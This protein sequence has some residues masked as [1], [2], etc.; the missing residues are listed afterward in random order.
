MCNFDTFSA[1]ALFGFLYCE[2]MTAHFPPRTFLTRL[3]LLALPT[4]PSIGSVAWAHPTHA[5]TNGTTESHTH[6]PFSNEVLPIGYDNNDWFIP[7]TTP[8]QSTP[9]PA[10]TSPTQATPSDTQ[11]PTQPNMQPNTQPKSYSDAAGTLTL[12]SGAQDWQNTQRQGVTLVGENLAV[13]DEAARGVVT[14]AVMNLP[15]FNELLPS[16][17]TRTWSKGRANLE[18]R[19]LQNGQWSAWYSFGTWSKAEGRRSA[20][21]QSDA[22]GKVDT[23]VLKLKSPAHA[24]Q[25][26]MHLEGQGVRLNL[27]AFHTRYTNNQH[28]TNHITQHTTNH[29]ANHNMTYKPE[30]AWGKVLSVPK[31][32]QMLYRGGE[33]WCSPTSVSMIL[34]RHGIQVSVPEAAKG[35]YDPVYDGTGNWPFNTAYAGE[36][37][38]K[39]FVTRLPDLNAAEAYIARG[40]PLALSAKWAKGELPQAPLAKTNGHLLVLIGFDASGNPIVHDPAASRSS[41]VRHTYPR[42]RFEQLWQAHNG[43]L[44]YVIAPIKT[45]LPLVADQIAKQQPTQRPATE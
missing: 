32:S 37:G 39:A 22:A 8:A 24:L 6:P 30:T 5:E 11:T 43:G 9:P 29:T 44:T 21:A 14:S 4:L 26:R 27:L 35:M 15:E 3:L 23:D 41:Q 38:L 45:P 25:Y 1:Q 16:W 19:V 12:I 31:R 10:N 17:N 33:S 28:N 7:P 2:I 36:H 34:G 18:V 13:T 42:Q 40:L 20:K